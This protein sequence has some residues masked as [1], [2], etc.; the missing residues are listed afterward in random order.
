MTISLIPLSLLAIGFTTASAQQAGTFTATGSMTT[1]RFRHTATLLPNGKVLI[2]G[3]ND[4]CY[5]GVPCIGLNT[6]EL[7]DPPTGT[8][9]PAGAMCLRRR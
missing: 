8:F 9:T 7:Y 2:A 4:V 1:L 3:G 6:A 5:L